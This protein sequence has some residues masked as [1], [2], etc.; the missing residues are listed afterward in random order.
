MGGTTYKDDD[1]VEKA[2]R[3]LPELEN[4]ISKSHSLL[5]EIDEVLKD[6]YINLKRPLNEH[7]E[8]KELEAKGLISELTQQSDCVNTRLDYLL[9]QLKSLRSDL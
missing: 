1:I 2:I 8:P 3:P 5:N 7:I 4:T 9:N 6:I